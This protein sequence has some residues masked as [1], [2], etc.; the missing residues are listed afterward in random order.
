VV[1]D[2]F[3]MQPPLDEADAPIAATAATAEAPPHAPPLSDWQRQ[4]ADDDQAQHSG[5][6]ARIAPAVHASE[7]DPWLRITAF[8]QHL[9]GVD[10][11]LAQELYVLPALVQLEPAAAAVLTALDEQRLQALA[12]TITAF[13]RRLGR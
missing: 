6:Y 7:W 1:L 11:R 3:V 5:A 13:L 8:P 12:L 10:A 9:M 2:Y 4:L